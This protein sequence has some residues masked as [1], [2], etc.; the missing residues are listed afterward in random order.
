MKALVVS[1]SVALFCL[2]VLIGSIVAQPNDY[3]CNDEVQNGCGVTVYCFSDPGQCED[4]GPNYVAYDQVGA[5]YF[6]CGPE[7]EEDCEEYVPI[8]AC[9]YTYYA[10]VNMGQ[11]DDE[12]NNCSPSAISELSCSKFNGT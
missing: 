6:M 4:N 11:C 3:A 1:V 2:L 9:V 8:F 7:S 12:I 5:S 10:T